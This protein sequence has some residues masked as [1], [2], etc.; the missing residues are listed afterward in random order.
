M[1][2][3]QIILAFCLSSAVLAHGNKKGKT[4]EAANADSGSGRR[5]G[6]TTSAAAAGG[7]GRKNGTTNAAA[8]CGEISRLTELT[9]LAQNATKLAE[10]QTKRN[11]TDAQIDELKTAATSANTR[12]TQLNS[13]TTLVSQC[14]IVNAD[15]Q[16]K[17]QCRSLARLTALSNLANNATALS[18]LQAKSNLTANQMTE[19]KA[20]AANAT[21]KLQELKSNATLTASCQSLQ[22]ASGTQG[23]KK[24]KTGRLIS[25][26]KTT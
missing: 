2:L 6:T 20:K 5:N 12:L 10:L 24:N 25:D 26:C 7:S 9:S 11:L 16:L 4:G 21:V 22:A 15:K 19:L 23:G 8:Q 17:S 18:A 13:N 14:A 3:K 1:Q